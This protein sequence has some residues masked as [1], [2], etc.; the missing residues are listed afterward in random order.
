MWLSPTGASVDDMEKIL[1]CTVEDFF[2][3]SIELAA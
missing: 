1:T 3:H 2:H